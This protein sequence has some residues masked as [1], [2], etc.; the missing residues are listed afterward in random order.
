HLGSPNPD[1]TYGIN[2]GAEYRRFDFS[3]FLYGSQ[4]NE[5]YSSVRRG[6]D[7]FGHY[8]QWNKSRNLL[9]AWTP[10]NKNTSIPRVES[11]E[12]F[13]TSGVNSSYFVEDGS[14]LKVR[15]VVLGYTVN[16]NYLNR[17]KISRLRFYAQAANLFTITEY[18]GLDP[19]IGGG[20]A[21]FGIDN[22]GYPTDE[23][24]LSLGLSITF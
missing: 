17:I 16:S 15:T 21:A 20:S 2:L 23:M 1:F 19:E 6:L 22:G 13:S 9:N 14:F 7:F 11:A 3:V 5:I 4:G 10:E 24:N 12:S 8:P 18:S